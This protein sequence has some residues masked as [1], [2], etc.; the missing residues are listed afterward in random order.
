MKLSVEEI[1]RVCHEVNRA[2]CQSQGDNTQL[3][4]EQAP[5]WAKKS[6][7]VGV[8]LHITNPDAGP[9]ASHESWFA[10]KDADGWVYGP[11]K[12]PE[13]KQHPCMVPFEDLP[14][15]QQAKDYIFRGVVRAL[16]E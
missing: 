10:Q 3:P 14:L 4:W 6:A 15:A 2:Y 8:N 16:A 13:F 7:I 12:L 9:K 5:E 1:A 11:E